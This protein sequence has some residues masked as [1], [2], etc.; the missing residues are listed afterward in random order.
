LRHLHD[1][2]NTL[3]HTNETLQERVRFKQA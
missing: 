1:A 2:N 3:C